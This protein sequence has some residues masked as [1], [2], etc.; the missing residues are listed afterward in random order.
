LAT[1]L[2][3]SGASSAS[4]QDAKARTEA[5]KAV[6]AVRAALESCDFPATPARVDALEAAERRLIDGLSLSDEAVNAL[7]GDVEGEL[8][9]RSWDKLCSD[10]TFKGQILEQ[11]S[12]LP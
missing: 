3:V 2:F 5:L 10:P 8:S 6:F 9:A 7:Y 4:A 11:L 12:Q 1:L